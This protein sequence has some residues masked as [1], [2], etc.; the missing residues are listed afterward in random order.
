M[1]KS[2]RLNREMR[3]RDKKREGEKR[4]TLRK[5]GEKQEINGFMGNNT[6]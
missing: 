6:L 1:E 3:K 4:V 2:R 5:K